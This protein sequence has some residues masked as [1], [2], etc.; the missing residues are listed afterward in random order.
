MLSVRRYTLCCQAAT[1]VDTLD[2]LRQLISIYES[3]YPETLK[4]AYV[5]RASSVFQLVFRL[6]Q[7]SSHWSPR[8]NT[9]R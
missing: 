5:V 4:A 9:E 6:V 8:L 3:N 7:V 1:N 2:I